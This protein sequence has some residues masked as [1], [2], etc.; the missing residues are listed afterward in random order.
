M[1]TKRAV[2]ICESW[3]NL[4][5]YA[6]NRMSSDDAVHAICEDYGITQDEFKV[7]FRIWCRAASR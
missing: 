3:T 4:T 2:G 1:T 7:A 5:L 6:E